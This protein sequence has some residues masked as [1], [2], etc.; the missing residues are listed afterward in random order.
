MCLGWNQVPYGT[1]IT[2]TSRN[3]PLTSDEDADLD[4]CE[5]AC[6]VIRWLQ[7][8]PKSCQPDGL[9]APDTPTHTSMLCVLANAI[10][11]GTTETHLR[12]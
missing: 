6:A 5:G 12:A 9:P 2:I 7:K 11:A 3:R 4:C 10:D 1:L 8:L